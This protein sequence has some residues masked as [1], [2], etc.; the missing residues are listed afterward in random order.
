MDRLAEGRIDDRRRH[1]A[2]PVS[3]VIADHLV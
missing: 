2:D 3:L 1:G